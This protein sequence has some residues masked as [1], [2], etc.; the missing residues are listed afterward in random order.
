MSDKP[1]ILLIV[2][3]QFRYDCMGNS[4]KYPVKTPNLDMLRNDG[5][6]FTNAYSPIP[7]CCPARQTIMS[8][9]T[10]ESLR[11]YWNYDLFPIDSL[12]PET[13]T[14]ISQLKKNGYV[15]SYLGKWHVS[16]DFGPVE[17]G[18]DVYTDYSPYYKLLNE[19][20]IVP[21]YKNGWMGEESSL[22]L[23]FSP[24]HWLA[25]TACEEI[26][27][28][29]SAGAPW[30]VRI[31][32][33]EPH[34][35]CRPSHPFSRMYDPA[36]VPKWD[37][38][39]DDFTDKPYIQKQQLYNWELQDKTWEDFANTVAMYYGIISQTD[40]AIGR[41]LKYLKDSGIYDDTLII[42]TSDH[43][44]MCG[45]HR[46]MDKHYVLY[47]DVVHVPLIVKWSGHIQS[48]SIEAG[49]VN[50]C[51]SIMPTLLD[52]AGI[53]YKSL[54]SGKSLLADDVGAQFA[55]STYNGQQ[56][57]LFTQ[58]M[59]RTAEWK[60][61]W[62]TTDIDELYDMQNDPG[63]LNNLIRNK[64]LLPVVTELRKKLYDYLKTMNDPLV[65]NEWIQNQLLNNGKI[66]TYS[67][68]NKL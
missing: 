28:L 5:K 68:E 64:E 44:D 13:E 60:Y 30:H 12:T 4:G 6:S 29:S 17:F 2:T 56:F 42:F 7:T 61:I 47:D 10:A 8:G 14:Y 41:V 55:V 39:D 3:D 50:N 36:S 24:T 65:N 66:E 43:G 46:M 26:K 23:E 1:N 51:L 22:P 9:K 49:F 45:S 15:S 62:N 52:A 40:D 18:Y 32:F 35:P 25:D 59:I 19:K 21:E 63:E 34:L 31:D 57:G 16:P 53:E 58:R 11:A 37:G 33:N 27:R 48:G 54:T 20:N 67:V 38:F